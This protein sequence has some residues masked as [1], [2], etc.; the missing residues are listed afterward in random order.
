MQ[1][2][3]KEVHSMEFGRGVVSKGRDG[4][5]IYKP[6]QEDTYSISLLE[7]VDRQSYDINSMLNGF[8]AKNEKPKNTYGS[9]LTYQEFESIKGI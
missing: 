2:H 5:V 9:P 7:I 1:D 8:E 6:N 4:T 3:Q